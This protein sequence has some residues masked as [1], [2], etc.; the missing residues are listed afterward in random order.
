MEIVILWLVGFVV[1]YILFAWVFE[2]AIDLI[3]WIRG[4]FCKNAVHRGIMRYRGMCKDGYE[5]SHCGYEWYEAKD[6]SGFK[7][8]S[9]RA[10]FRSSD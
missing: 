10:K 9:D 1:F 8:F 3:N 4:A 2:K 5:C 6:G 7:P